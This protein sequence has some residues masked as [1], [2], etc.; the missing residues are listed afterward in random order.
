VLVQLNVPK[1]DAHPHVRLGVSDD[2][3]RGESCLVMGDIQR[4]F[5]ARRERVCHIQV[6]ADKAQVRNPGS[7]TR[8]GL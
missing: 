2:A 3:K 7:E 4:D 1:S 8:I 5:R 6:A